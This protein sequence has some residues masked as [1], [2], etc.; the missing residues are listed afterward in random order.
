MNSINLLRVVSSQSLRA[1]KTLRAQLSP[2]VPSIPHDLPFCRVDG[3]GLGVAHLGNWTQRASPPLNCCVRN[4]SSYLLPG[5]ISIP[6]WR[7][8]YLPFLY[9][10]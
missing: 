3:Q 2:L 8:K 5:Q 1:E 7:F 9:T 4:F 6:N 10:D